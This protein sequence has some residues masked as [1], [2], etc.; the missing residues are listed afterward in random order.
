MKQKITISA[1]SLTLIMLVPSVS[2]AQTCPAGYTCTQTSSTDDPA[3]IAEMVKKI[4]FIRSEIVRLT[5]L[6]N[7]GKVLGASV[8]SSG[9]ARPPLIRN[10]AITNITKNGATISWYT[11]ENAN[12]TL[13]YSTNFLHNLTSVSFLSTASYS[14]FHTFNLTGLNPNSVYYYMLRSVDSSNN[15]TTTSGLHTFTTGN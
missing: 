6:R 1:I 11:S 10:V 13:W 2:G 8:S 3:V 4:E 12:A 14:T 9:D 5:A 15:T 7:Q